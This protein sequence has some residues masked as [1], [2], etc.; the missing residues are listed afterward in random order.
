MTSSGP[1]DRRAAVFAVAFRYAMLCCVSLGASPARAED[2]LKVAI[3]QM[4]AWA[5]QPPILGSEAGIFKKHGLV[6]ASFGTQGAGETLQPV[7]SGAADI[8]IGIGTAG[9]MRAF[10]KGAPVRI[11]GASFTGMGDIFWYVKADSPIRRLSDASER[12]TIAYST[13]GATSHSVVLAFVSELGVKARP[14][15]TGG[16][17]A[18]LTQ[19]MSGQIDIGWSVPPFGLKEVEDGKIRIVASGNDAVSMRGQTVRVQTVNAR[20]AVERRDVLIRF[21][22]AYREA[23]DWIFADP[24]AMALYAA[25]NK[26]PEHIVKQTAEQFQTRVGMQFDTIAGVDAIMAEGVRHK[27]LDAPLTKAQLAELIQIPPPGS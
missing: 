17:P 21:V 15:S 5:Q 10:S 6:L 25:A 26:V 24:R 4:E 16:L 22:R 9:V 14:T 13:N 3:G 2:T 8:G 23:L 27:F 12:N 20:M 19:V 11:F 1:H 18:T 7:I